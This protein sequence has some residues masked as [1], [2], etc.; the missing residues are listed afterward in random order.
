M[1]TTPP[2]LYVDDY[3]VLE[4]IRDLTHLRRGDHCM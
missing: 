4:E 3:H 2:T 1:D